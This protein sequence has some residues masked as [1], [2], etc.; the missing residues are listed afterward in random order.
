MK[1]VFIILMAFSTLAAFGKLRKWN[2]KMQELGKTFS[3]LLV[4]V[5]GSGPMTPEAKK[6]LVEGTKHLSA[7]AHTVK[8]GVV[9]P[10][11]D[12][13]LKFVSGLF[14]R[15]AKLAHH[16]AKNGEYAYA[17]TT[18]RRMAGYCLTCHTRH[19]KGPDFPTLEINPKIE[20]LSPTERGELF[21]ALRQFDQA[22]VEFEKVAGDARIAEHKPFEWTRAVRHAFAITVRVKDD[23]EIAERIITKALSL[24]DAP[25]FFREDAI[26]WKENINQWKAD[27]GKTPVTEEGYF[28][29]AVRLAEAAKAKQQYPLDHSQDVQYL[30]V[31]ALV[32]QQLAKFPDGKRVSEALL[33]AG[34]AYNVLETPILNPL[35]EFY[36]EA[37]IRQSPRTAVA[38]TCFHRYEAAIFFG[39]SGSGGTFIPEDVKILMAELRKL[40]EEP[41]QNE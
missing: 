17:R 24:P 25:R 21:A 18:V 3:T 32:H 38:R 2:Q 22:L 39:Y 41:R 35:P 30:R 37:C 9:P 29:E 34:N 13:T 6:R 27:K 16:A 26:A 5:S 19:D 12:P 1:R 36:F 28:L 10:E 23:P 14:E 4:D 8:S 15:E 11:A 40:S 7:L 20:A 33:L 31:T